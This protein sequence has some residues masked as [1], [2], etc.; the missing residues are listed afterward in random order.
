VLVV[1]DEPDAREVLQVGLGIWGA[2]VTTAASAAEAMLALKG[3][4]PDVL[5]SDIGMP[6]EDGYSLIRRVRQLPEAQGGKVLA[7]A[8][9]AFARTDDRARAL[10]AGYH[11]HVAKPVEPS[12]LA[13]IVADLLGRDALV[14]SSGTS[15]RDERAIDLDTRT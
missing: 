11:A 3:D 5:L 6:V 2:R 10:E 9:T 15:M 14:P 8:L 4:V 7:V 1:D 12:K 13:A